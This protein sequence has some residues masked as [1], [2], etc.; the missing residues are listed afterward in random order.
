MKKNLKFEQIHRDSR[1]S[2]RYEFTEKPYQDE[3]SLHFHP[4]I[5][6]IYIYK[7]SGYRMTGDHLEPFDEGEL[8]FA[9]PHL[10]H[11]WIYSPESCLPDG[12]RGCICV[13]FLPEVLEKGL[14]FFPECEY[15][16]HRLLEISQGVRVTGETAA[17]VTRIM[18]DMSPQSTDEKL[19]SLIRIVQILGTSTEFVPIGMPVTAVSNITKNM[20][21]MQTVYKYIVENYTVSISLQDISALINMTP[22]AFCS[23]FKRETGK[24]FNSFVNEYRIQIV[25][26]LLRNYPEREISQIAGQCGFYD[27]PYF[28]RTFRKMTGITPGEWRRQAAGSKL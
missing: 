19:L 26:N 15:A 18:K 2:Y 11:C 12:N 9:P 1:A 8:I 3:I 7:G 14:T 24:T 6:L 20:Q 28:N 25:C 4:E 22:T 23:F 13:Q 10:P 27:V 16:A 21:R 5:E 17:K